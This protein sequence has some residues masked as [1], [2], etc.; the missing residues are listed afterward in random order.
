[1][2]EGLIFQYT[3][4]ESILHR[5][6]IRIKLIGMIALSLVLIKVS[7]FRLCFLLPVLLS[8]DICS[9]NDRRI[10]LPPPILFLMPLIIFAGNFISLGPWE[11]GGFKPALAAAGFRALRFIC[12][13]WMAQLFTETSDPMSITPAFY[14][15]LKPIPLIPAG[16]ISTSMG[17]SLTLIPLIISEMGEIRDAMVSRCGWNPRRPVR[18]LTSMGIPLLEGVLTRAEAL[19]D[20]MESRLFTEDATEPELLDDSLRTSPSLFLLLLLT[21]LFMGER[22]L[23][24]IDILESFMNFY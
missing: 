13:L 23:L 10:S 3:P 9:R 20:A 2:A 16:R 21:A 12:I 4:G 6:D 24:N 11:T 8:L 19:S 7:P 1:M 18:N 22:L 14:R 15:L 5:I 17:L